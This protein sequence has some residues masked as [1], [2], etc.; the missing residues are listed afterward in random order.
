MLFVQ[1]YSRII[2]YSFIAAI[3]FSLPLA[4]L[5][6]ENINLSGKKQRIELA[7][8]D[9]GGARSGGSRINRPSGGAL[10]SGSSRRLPASLGSSPSGRTGNLSQARPANRRQQIQRPQSNIR[11]SSEA[12]RPQPSGPSPSQRQRSSTEQR[13][14]SPPLNTGAGQLSNQRPQQ[15]ANITNRPNR[16]RNVN[17]I[18][19]PHSVNVEGYDGGWGYQGEDYPWGLGAAAGMAGLTLGSV[20][21]ALPSNSQPVVIQGQPYYESSGMYFAPSDGGNYT[22]VPPPPGAVEVQLPSGA[23]PVNIGGLALYEFQ[24]VYY[25]PTVQNG[26]QTYMVVVP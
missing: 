14:S 1:I 13:P 26:K 20:L 2:V 16:P 9:R 23:K 25:Q 6:Q 10:G 11:G 12:R 5:A 21:N 4:V 7:R 15:P 22:V 17:Q 8:G 3:S 24:G 18:N 19:A